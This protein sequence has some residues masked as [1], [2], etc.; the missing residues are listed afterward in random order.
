MRNQLKISALPL[1]KVSIPRTSK[2]IRRTFRRTSN[3]GAKKRN[4]QRVKMNRTFSTKEAENF[5]FLYLPGLTAL[6]YPPNR[7][8]F[9]HPF[10]YRFYPFCASPGRRFSL[11]LQMEELLDSYLV[12][13]RL[14]VADLLMEN[15]PEEGIF[16]GIRGNPISDWPTIH[17]RYFLYRLG[18]LGQV[19][20]SGGPSNALKRLERLGEFD[21]HNP[22][23]FIA[24]Y[25]KDGLSS[26]EALQR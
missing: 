2:G 6:L 14:F 19:A 1:R 24:I 22:E 21:V 10:T 3:K 13:C 23:G 9:T 18:I 16:G 7:L 5:L 25:Q 17:R 8:F 4:I 12:N 20:R 11:P 15:T 26:E